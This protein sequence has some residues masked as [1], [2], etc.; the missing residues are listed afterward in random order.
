M[1]R[2]ASFLDNMFV[3]YFLKHNIKMYELYPQE[4]HAKL[5]TFDGI[6]SS[7]GTIYRVTA[8]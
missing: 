6:I 2:S 7:I 1:R 3:G 5:A 8:N 4:L